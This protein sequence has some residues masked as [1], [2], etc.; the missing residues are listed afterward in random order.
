[1][2]S[3][4]A[5]VLLLGFALL[6][7]AATPLSA[8]MREWKSADGTQSFD[9]EYVSHDS[10]KVTIKR[11]DGK[12]FSLELERLNNADKIWLSDKPAT[13]TPGEKAAAETIDESKTV[14]DTL[15][16]G[17]KREVV[18]KKLKESSFVEATMDEVMMGRT[19]LN[20]VFR[21]RKQIGGLHCELYFDF[22]G[23][24]SLKEISLQTQTVPKDV[25][26]NRLKAT[27][28]ELAELLTALNGKPVQAGAFPAVNTLRQDVLIP[29]HLWK[30]PAG[31]SALLGT[32]LE[33]GDKV[34]IVVRF[35]TDPIRPVEVP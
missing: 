30:L 17:D 15:C 28:A 21:T 1:M 18:T 32:S 12:V 19:G 31:G 7:L 27:W 35:T 5:N 25:Y 9:G 26:V 3:P 24:G 14:F 2:P 6:G 8:E 10:K 29:S 16:F 11:K 23:S 34:M 13:E 4:S 20:G 22:N 33:A